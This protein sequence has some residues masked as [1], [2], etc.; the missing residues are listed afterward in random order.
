MADT[1]A[2]IPARS[3]S[4]GVPHKNIRALGGH[5]LMA[6]TIAACRRSGLI[7]RVIVSTDSDEY[8]EIARRYGAE[9]PF[10]R[11]AK[12][13]G[14]NSPDRE[15]VLHALDW[16]AEAGGEPTNVAQMRPTTPFRDPAIIDRA[17]TA[18]SENN[19]ASALRSVHEMSESS[20]KTF[21]ITPDGWLA[22]LGL[23]DL[24]LDTVNLARQSFPATFIANGYVD[25][26]SVAFIRSTGLLHGDRVM[27]FVTPPAVEVDREIDFEFL[28]FRVAQDPLLTKPVEV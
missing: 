9:V 7:D 15:F 12:F 2:L 16:L 5:P 6:Y 8:A 24:T 4:Q 28:E 3:G 22:T 14:S 19:Q 27:A 18:F 20:Y 21:E 25:V 23:V 26:L 13:S 1:I 11:P 17:I 10:L